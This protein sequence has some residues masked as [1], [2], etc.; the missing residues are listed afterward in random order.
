MSHRSSHT[1]RFF[2]DQAALAQA[3]TK[4]LSESLQSQH[5]ERNC[6]KKFADTKKNKKR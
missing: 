6:F 1:S 5:K 4:A 2:R 3:Q